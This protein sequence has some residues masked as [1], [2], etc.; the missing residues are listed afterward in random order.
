[1]AP[2]RQTHDLAAAGIIRTNG[3]RQGFVFVV[4]ALLSIKDTALDNCSWHVR[5]LAGH[6]KTIF[7]ERHAIRASRTRWI[8]LR[9]ARRAG[10]FRYGPRSLW[11]QGRTYKVGVHCSESGEETCA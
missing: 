6:L 4:S 1:V 7:G 9:L 2:A 8:P 10:N 5:S 3:S 11:G